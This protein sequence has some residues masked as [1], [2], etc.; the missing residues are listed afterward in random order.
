MPA[1]ND[2]LFAT[3][4][5]PVAEVAPVDNIDELVPVLL[6]VASGR[7]DLG[8]LRSLPDDRRTAEVRKALEVLI[9]AGH[10][11]LDWDGR[12]RLLQALVD[13]LLGL[14]PLGPLLRDDTVS[15]IMVNG[16]DQVFV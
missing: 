3:D 1:A 12:E 6:N 16:P 5:L 14:G 8:R 4:D 7:L 9:D 15:E 2:R 13:E 11:S 10:P